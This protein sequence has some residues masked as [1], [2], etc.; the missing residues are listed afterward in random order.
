[1]IGTYRAINDVFSTGSITGGGAFD[2]MFVEG[3]GDGDTIYLNGNAYAL[4]GSTIQG[5]Q[6]ND[7]IAVILSG[8]SQ[9]SAT[10]I[11]GGGG[12]DVFSGNGQHLNLMTA[13]SNT[14]AGGGGADSIN[15]TFQASATS[16][17]ILGDALNTLGEYDGNDLITL[18]TRSDVSSN[19]VQA[20]GGNDTLRLSGAQGGSN[21]FQMQAGDD[22][23]S[24]DFGVL[25]SVTVQMGAGADSVYIYSGGLSGGSLVNLGGGDDLF[26]YSAMNSGANSD[27]ASVATVFGGLGADTFT[28]GHYNS[29]T[30]G[31]TIGYSS[32][33]DSTITAFDTIAIGNAAASGSY[34]LQYEPGGA[35][36]AST[37]GT[38]SFTATN[39]VAIFTGTY[40]GSV[41]ARYNELDSTITTEGAS[42]IFFDSGNVTYFF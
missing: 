8:N 34:T 3:G 12:N 38:N 23:V 16:N 18:V 29:G 35:T 6:G 31:I 5:G 28:A 10:Q 15:I 21:L 41:T 25:T 42:T 13:V 37:A 14:I 32:I 39:G 4:N 27:A 26:S 22:L 2:N 19:T 30:V 33:S 36:L 1:M 9:L 24:A 40:D 7:T 11:L 17:Y 20:G